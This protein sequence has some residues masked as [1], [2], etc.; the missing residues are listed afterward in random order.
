[1]SKG[2]WF[3]DKIT[4]CEKICVSTGYFEKYFLNDPRMKSCEYRKGRKVLWETEKAK[5]YVKDIIIEISQ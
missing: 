5:K 4:L 3:I 2:D 1:M